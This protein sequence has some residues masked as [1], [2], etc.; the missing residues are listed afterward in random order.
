MAEGQFNPDLLL[1]VG[2]DISSLRQ[3]LAQISRE[4]NIPPVQ[5]KV[6]AQTGQIQQINTALTETTRQ[7][8]AAGDSFA[9][10][11]GQMNAVDKIAL[12]LS[13]KRYIIDPSAFQAS[14]DAA[15]RVR[16]ALAT[17]DQVTREVNAGVTQGRDAWATF[18]RA[19][20]VARVET[21]RIVAIE[22]DRIKQTQVQISGISATTRAVGEL[23]A[24]ER[25]SEERRVGKECRSRW[26]PYH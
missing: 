3:Q 14:E 2:A 10:L 18:S 6:E 15:N 23:T 25:R 16:A 9:K 26:S 24:A 4:L 17:I 5:V 20:T 12:E 8:G 1:T 21:E 13:K 22:A 11:Q 19:V 7:A